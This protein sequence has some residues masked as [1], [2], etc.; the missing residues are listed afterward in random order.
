MQRG[1]LVSPPPPNQVD[2]FDDIDIDEEV[3]SEQSDPHVLILPPNSPEHENT[4]ATAARYKVVLD[5]D[6]ES[7]QTFSPFLEMTKKIGK[8]K[9]PL[10][11]VKSDNFFGTKK[12]KNKTK[13][14]L[15]I[16]AKLTLGFLILLILSLIGALGY[17]YITTT[18]NSGSGLLEVNNPTTSPTLAPT[19]SPTTP[20]PTLSPTDAPS[21]SPTLT[22]T[23]SP[24]NSPSES[25]TKFPTAF[26]SESPTNFPTTP[27]PTPFPT[28]PYP[29]L[30]P[31][32]SPTPFP[33]TPYPTLFPTTSPTLSPTPFPTTPFPTS[34]PTDAPTL[35]PT[36]P[37]PTL[38][39]TTSL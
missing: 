7:Q 1:K 16:T 32:E 9:G 6:N 34:F 24:T 36:T 14:K 3:F 37:F 4:P 15:G 5:E 26:P 28:T 38:F 18:N 12:E 25:P 22:P 17:T 23:K 29:T 19:Y 27:Y 8:Q 10:G 39:P 11:R 30:Y 20:F 35:F 2:T 33:T 21:K 31:T 13:K